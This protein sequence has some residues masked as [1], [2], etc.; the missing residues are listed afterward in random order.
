[1]F[2]VECGGTFRLSGNMMAQISSPNYPDGAQHHLN[3]R[4]NFQAEPG[5]RVELTL[6]I[7]TEECCDYIDVSLST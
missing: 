6:E 5:F 4:Y 2:S 1:M 3:C 7:N